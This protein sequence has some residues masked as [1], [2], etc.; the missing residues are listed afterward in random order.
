MGELLKMTSTKWKEPVLGAPH[1]PGEQRSDV[2]KE[3]VAVS[4]SMRHDDDDL[5]QRKRDQLEMMRMYTQYY[6]T[7]W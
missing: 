4:R 2:T 5:P 3:P 7:Y 6:S 1:K